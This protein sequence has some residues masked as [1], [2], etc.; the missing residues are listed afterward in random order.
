MI[1]HHAN[2][3]GGFRGTSAIRDA[4]DETW[5]LK[6][7]TAE[8]IEKNPD[9]RSVRFI[10][11]EKSRSGR[12]GTQLAMRMESDLTFSVSDATPEIDPGKTTPDS[13]VDRVLTKIRTVYPRWITKAE[14][15]SDSITGGRGDSHKK[16]LQR[17]VKKGL[18]VGVKAEGNRGK[19]SY[20]AVL[21]RARGEGEG[22]AS[23]QPKPSGGKDPVGGQL[24]GQLAKSSVSEPD[25]PPTGKGDAVP[26][27][28]PPKESSAGAEFARGDTSAETPHARAHE[29]DLDRKSAFD[30]WKI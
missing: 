30:R 3:S 7:P 18:I 27:S 22:G 19:V 29:G 14:I 26:P 13:I 2:K 15:D 1:V 17:L 28:C 25:V 16:A 12:S 11:I 6:R 23:P 9:L 5:A 21:A 24:G 10:N 20:Q 4:V 8:Q